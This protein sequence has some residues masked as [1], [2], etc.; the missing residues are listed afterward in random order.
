MSAVRLVDEACDLF[1]SGIFGNRHALWIERVHCTV[2][3]HEGA[4]RYPI[5]DEDTV[6]ATHAASPYNSDRIRQL[7]QM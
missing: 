3:K 6:I 5:Q 2:R 1:D 7:D 4:L